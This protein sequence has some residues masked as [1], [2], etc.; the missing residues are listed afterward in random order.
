[1][2]EQEDP[3]GPD[4]QADLVREERTQWLDPIV[5]VSGGFDPTHEGHLALF[6]AAAEYGKVHVLLNSDE[7]L[8]RKKG[9]FLL[10]WETRKELLINLSAIHRVHAVD[11]QDDTVCNGLEELRKTYPNTKML[12]AN[13]GDRKEG[14]TP[15]TFV[16][17]TY[18]IEVLW[19]IGGEKVNSSSALLS[20]YEH[21]HKIKHLI[22]R[23][24][25]TYEIIAQGRGFLTKILTIFP[26]KH[27]SYQRHLHRTEEWLVLE[28][29]GLFIRDHNKFDGMVR[30]MYPTDRMGIPPLT[31]HW[32]K[33]TSQNEPLR[34]LETW[35]GDILEESDIEREDSHEATVSK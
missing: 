7:W 32:V 12:F 3:L 24:W 25:G 26:R 15:E 22:S 27:I 1:M 30:K 17:R 10:P 8:T 33:N 21:K 34:I 18:K 9:S 23:N 11:D 13:G 5:V 2:K 28:G 6:N 16:C 20:E 35:F 19:N 29:S 31:W 14:N 4:P